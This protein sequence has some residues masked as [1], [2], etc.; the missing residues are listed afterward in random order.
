MSK[1]H[2]ALAV[3][4]GALASLVLAANVRVPYD[5]IQVQVRVHGHRFAEPVWVTVTHKATRCIWPLSCRFSLLGQTDDMFRHVDARRVL[6]AGDRLTVD[7]VPLHVASVGADRLEGLTI[8]PGVQ[9]LHFAGVE[10]LPTAPTDDED[11]PYRGVLNAA[12]REGDAAVLRTHVYFLPSTIYFYTRG[13]RSVRLELD[14]GPLPVSQFSLR[15]RGWQD[16]AHA[17]S[18][19]AV[20]GPGIVL[21]AGAHVP[22][23]YVT[24]LAS[25]DWPAAQ[26]PL[27][28]LSPDVATQ[29]VLVDWATLRDVLGVK[30]R[31]RRYV[32]MSRADWDALR[33][34]ADVGG[35]VVVEPAALPGAL[36]VTTR[37]NVTARRYVLIAT[38]RPGDALA[39]AEALELDVHP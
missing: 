22:L 13:L 11:D 5:K 17:A 39:S 1:F 27:T 32:P 20:R 21:P 14:V 6:P 18:G 15:S 35:E 38:F 37:P 10:E 25:Q 4:G 33:R 9:P 2:W 36:I 8:Q 7:A 29:S 28:P 19:S 3:V 34:R 16:G 23:P 31:Y 24:S 30:A 12:P 26:G